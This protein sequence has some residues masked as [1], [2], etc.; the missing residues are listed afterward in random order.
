MAVIYNI[1]LILSAAV[2]LW[3][4]TVPYVFQWYSYIPNE[5]EN[6]IVSINYVNIFFSLLLSGYSLLL[7]F[8]RKKII[9]G[10]KELLIMYGFMVFVWFCRTAITFI[11]PVPI[12]SAV[13][14]VYGQQIGAFV[15][16]LLQLIPFIFLLKAGRKIWVK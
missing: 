16:F 14:I 4:F 9:N 8:F 12:K 7:L 15:I 10:N 2:G 6:L 11:E 3:H 13:C 1:G 5:Y